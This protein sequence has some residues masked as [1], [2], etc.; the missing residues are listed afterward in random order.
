[1]K[2]K[3]R[4]P[5]ETLFASPGVVP[6]GSGREPGVPYSPNI[7]AAHLQREVT[8]W[9][10]CLSSQASRLTGIAAPVILGFRSANP[11]WRRRVKERSS[12]KKSSIDPANKVVRT[13]IKR[14]FTAGPREGRAAA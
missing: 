1:M 7:D 9:K 11:E 5:I 2:R 13:V 10:T 6:V 12:G 14:R 3:D 4:L 8:Y